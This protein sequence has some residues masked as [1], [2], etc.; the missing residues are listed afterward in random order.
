MDLRITKPIKGGTVRAIASKSAAHRLLICAAL[1]DAVTDVGCPERSGDIEATARCLGALGAEVRYGGEGYR[2][3]PIKAGPDAYDASSA[4]PMML[5]CGESGSTL[6]FLLPICGALGRKVTLAMGGRLPERPLGA[7]H[8]EMASHGCALSGLGGAVLSCEGRLG[9]G[10][11]SLPGDV[12]SQFVSGLMLALPLVSGDSQITVEGA[13]ES[14]PYVDLTL[15]ALRLFGVRAYEDGKGSFRIP[16]GQAY[17]SPGRAEVE[18]DWSSASAWLAAGAI[19]AGSVTCANLSLDSRQGDR[20]MTGILT[21]FGADVRLGGGSVTVYPGRLR[22]I[23]VDA[24]D[25]PDLVPM[26]AAVA[27]VAEGRTVITGAGRLRGKESDRLRA[28]AALFSGLGADVAETADGLAICGRKALEGGVADS[29]GDHRIAMAAAV[30]A[31]A[32]VGAVTVR[33]A[34][35]VAKSYPGFWDDYAHK[36]GGMWEES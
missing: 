30:I 14:R 2:V 17:R 25:V 19:G 34:E 28:L 18:G 31:S 24:A 35:A 13:L 1:S 11:Y 5:D 23:E 29:F 33:G 6:R 16:G 26:V 32:C 3:T 12:S 4:P 36:L 9:S 7:L 22:G 10:A 27:S 20:A 21:R 8:R 15:D